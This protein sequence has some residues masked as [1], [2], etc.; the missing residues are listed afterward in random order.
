MSTLLI[1]ILA[2]VVIGVIPSLI[3]GA[4]LTKDGLARQ[5]RITQ[6]KRFRTSVQPKTAGFTDEDRR[7]V[8]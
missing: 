8:V 4:V 5:K 2:V 1:V 7:T 6:M 3:I